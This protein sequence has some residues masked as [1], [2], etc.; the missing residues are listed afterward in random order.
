MSDSDRSTGFQ[1]QV[2]DGVKAGRPSALAQSLPTDHGTTIRVVIQRGPSWA[3]CE[4]LATIELA[5]LP[6]VG[7]EIGLMVDDQPKIYAVYALRH[8]EIRGNIGGV[9]LLVR[10]LEKEAADNI[11]SFINAIS[12]A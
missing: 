8:Y 4:Y 10:D 6:R 3:G 12:D 7:E 5:A 11:D 2:A 1:S 9:A